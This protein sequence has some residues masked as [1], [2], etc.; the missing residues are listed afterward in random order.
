MRQTEGQ[1]TET[2]AE[3]NVKAKRQADKEKEAERSGGREGPEECQ[4]F[5]TSER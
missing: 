4:Q 5:L 3:K 2:F 1:M